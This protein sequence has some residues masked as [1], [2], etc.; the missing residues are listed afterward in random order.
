MSTS[1]K[2]AI[3]PGSFDP[4]TRGHED[5]VRRGLMLFDEIVIAIG[6]NSNKQRY[7]S[8]DM[9]LERIA[10]TFR[11]EH[12]VSVAAFHGLTG[13]FAKSIDAQFLLRGL[14]NTT[15]FEYENT[16]AQANAH[17]FPGLDTVFLITEPAL[18]SISS[19]IVRDLHK[20][21]A[22]VR[23]FLPYDLPVVKAS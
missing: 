12:R 2:T 11:D 4:F 21:G 14:R 9:M 13:H 22:D 17:V 20:Y 5:V 6:V 10:H 7:L 18:A 3:F 23:S 19:S 16:I 8:I 15:D 1:K